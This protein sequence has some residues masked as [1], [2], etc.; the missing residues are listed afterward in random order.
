MNTQDIIDDITSKDIQK[1]RT[2]SCEIID[3]GQDEAKIKPLIPFIELI[4]KETNG[5]DLGGA[6]A[7]NK[8]FPEYAIKTIE[9]HRDRNGCT[10]EL[11][12]GEYDCFDPR[13]EYKKGH[14]KLT[15][16]I[17]GDWAYDYVVE[18][19]KCGEHYDVMERN[20]HYTWWKWT[21]KLKTRHNPG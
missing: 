17:K 3:S 12:A 9:F 8:R 2:S 5:L 10:C 4:R 16:E 21:K 18:C 20:G 7:P 1:I 11:Y 19:Q 6:F 13:Q 14:I 15:S